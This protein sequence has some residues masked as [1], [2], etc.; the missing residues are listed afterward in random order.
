MDIRVHDEDRRSAVMG[1]DEVLPSLLAAFPEFQETWEAYTTSNLYGPDE[2]YN[3]TARL[4]TFL[5]TRLQ[6]TETRGFDR[7]FEAVDWLLQS[8]SPTAREILIVGLLE[9]LQNISLNSSVTLES[10][11]Q[12]LGPTTLEA[13]TKV[14]DMWD[15]TL[16]PEEF[17]MYVRKGR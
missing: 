9:D 8:G 16:S 1:P 5:V 11:G 15:G 13:W 3:D 17:N 12:W 4:A 14:S 10:W 2:P 6:A 7:L